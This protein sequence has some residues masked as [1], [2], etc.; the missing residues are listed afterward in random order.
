MIG[1]LYIKRYNSAHPSLN[2]D[3]IG[4]PTQLLDSFQYATSKENGTLTIVCIVN[5]VL[6][7]SHLTLGE[8]IVVINEIDLDACLGDRGHFD[9]Q[10]VVCIVNNQIHTRETDDLMQLSAALIDIAPFGH[11]RT[12]LVTILQ[13]SLREC[14]SHQ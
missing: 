11:E 3:D 10:W 2:M 13:H 1:C 5:A 6:V 4:H 7:N 12:N 9:N 14:F 8:I